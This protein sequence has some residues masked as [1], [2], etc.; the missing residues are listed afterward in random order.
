VHFL[1]L[2]KNS[3]EVSLSG[4]SY[5][6]EIFVNKVIEYEPELFLAVTWD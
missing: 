1:E 3:F 6:T 2:D 5:Q 4:F